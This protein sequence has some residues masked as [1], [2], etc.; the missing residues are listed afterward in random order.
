[1]T[2]VYLEVDD[3]GLATRVLD[4]LDGVGEVAPEGRGLSVEL[5]GIERKTI[6]AALVRAG[7]GVETIT[8]RHHLED[9]FI[10][11]LEHQ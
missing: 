7:V 4:A 1:M 6:T 8:A 3:V 11:L 2:A 10:G 5:D 9:A